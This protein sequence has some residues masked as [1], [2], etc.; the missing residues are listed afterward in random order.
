[1]NVLLTVAFAEG[2]KTYRAVGFNHGYQ[3]TPSLELEALQGNRKSS[4]FTPIQTLSAENAPAYLRKLA[5]EIEAKAA[6]YLKAKAAELAKKS[7]ATPVVSHAEEVHSEVKAGIVVNPFHHET[8]QE[9]QKK[10]PLPDWLHEGMDRG[11]TP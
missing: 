4:E 7:A 3:G 9:D 1:M 8:K 11:E 2:E 6:P 10:I 5:D